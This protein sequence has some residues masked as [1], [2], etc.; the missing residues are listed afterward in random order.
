MDK[1]REEDVRGE[2]VPDPL[3]R[4]EV[5]V[6]HVLVRE[7]QAAVLGRLLLRLDEELPQADREV[8]DEGLAVARRVESFTSRLGTVV[9][10]FLTN[11]EAIAPEVRH[12]VVTAELAR[13][14][15]AR[16]VALEDGDHGHVFDFDARLA[17]ANRLPVVRDRP[18]ADA[19]AETVRALTA[20][21]DVAASAVHGFC[22]SLAIGPH[23]EPGCIRRR[24]RD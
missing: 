14:V 17:A 7:L 15:V 22:G 12:E 3:A 11:V 6:D 20:D 23:R 2:R 19:Q 9:D 8:V 5:E 4:V 24:K 1:F 13:D 16:E 18:V 10:E 21:A